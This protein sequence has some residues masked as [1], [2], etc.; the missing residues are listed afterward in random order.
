[1]RETVDFPN[2]NATADMKAAGTYLK[3]STQNYKLLLEQKD[4]G[5]LLKRQ[6]HIEPIRPFEDLYRGV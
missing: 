3:A 5:P 1:M 2:R 6:Y 4:W